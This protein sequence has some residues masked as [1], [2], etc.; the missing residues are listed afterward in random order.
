MKKIIH[1]A[2][3]AIR[4]NMKTGGNEPA[5]IVR[6]YRGAERYHELQLVVDGKV[7]G[8][9]KYQP[10]DPL[11]CGAR[12]WLE[13]DSEICHVEEIASEPSQDACPIA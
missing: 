6:D 4:R 12:V 9:F 10:H 11:P 2:Q 13:L 7:I 5:L 3:D 1:V 8:T